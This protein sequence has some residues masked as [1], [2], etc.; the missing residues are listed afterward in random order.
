PLRTAIGT[1]TA[2][3]ALSAL[4]G[5]LGYGWHHEIDVIGFLLIGVIAVTTGYLVA[6]YAQGIRERYQV[7]GTG[8]LL[9]A[10]GVWMLVH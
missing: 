10:V 9:F 2:A 1:G 8:L 7:G 4:S 6:H 5:A 3:M